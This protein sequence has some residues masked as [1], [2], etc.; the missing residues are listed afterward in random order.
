MIDDKYGGSKGYFN[1][2]DFKGRVARDI[3]PDN[4]FGAKGGTESV[5]LTTS[6]IPTH[7]H[8]LPVSSDVGSNSNPCNFK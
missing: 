1:L 6:N 7:S 2:P 5:T 8:K 4:D 3:S